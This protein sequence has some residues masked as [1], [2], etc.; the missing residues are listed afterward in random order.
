MSDMPDTTERRAVRSWFEMFC[1]LSEKYQ[2]VIT[3]RD[4]AG[5]ENH[6]LSDELQALRSELVD[7]RKRVEELSSLVDAQERRIK[8][9]TEEYEKLLLTSADWQKRAAVWQRRTKYLTNA[10]LANKDDISCKIVE[11][12]RYTR[13]VLDNGPE[14]DPLWGIDGFPADVERHERVKAKIANMTPEEAH[15][16][17]ER[18][19]KFCKEGD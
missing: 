5:A 2:K 4:A 18:L 11:L 6:R 14:S 15:A 1:D 13:K 8:L 3:E 19:E 12:A 9:D 16:A 7:A 17:R 10:I